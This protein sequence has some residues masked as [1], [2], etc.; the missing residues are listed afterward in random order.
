[1]LDFA[2]AHHERADHAHD[3]D[4]EIYCAACGQLMT[5]GRWR[6]AATQLRYLIYDSDPRA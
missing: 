1:M 6:I 3:T 4:D 2:P 5:R